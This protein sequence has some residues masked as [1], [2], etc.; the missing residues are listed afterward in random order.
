MRSVP[1]FGPYTN[2]QQARK[3]VLC[4]P[5]PRSTELAAASFSPTENC[6]RID[7]A[8]ASLHL[9]AGAGVE[10]RWADQVVAWSLKALR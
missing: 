9:Q 10:W 1:M 3:A 6:L 7:P 8:R 2:S 5:Q 4:L